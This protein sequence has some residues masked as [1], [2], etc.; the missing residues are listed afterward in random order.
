MDVVLCKLRDFSSREMSLHECGAELER[1][2]LGNGRR[3]GGQMDLE[4][5]LAWLRRELMLLR[6]QDQALIRQLMDL[7]QGIQELRQECEVA[8]KDDEDEAGW[9]SGSEGAGS[10]ISS[11]SSGEMSICPPLS[12][13]SYL[14]PAS[15]R[16]GF[17]RRSSVP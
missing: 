9:F 14:R 6:S 12:S 1:V 15:L 17:G 4:S 3:D 5:A 11:C 8:T 2:R 13:I 16:R 10:S 7:H